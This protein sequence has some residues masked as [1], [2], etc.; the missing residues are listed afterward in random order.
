MVDILLAVYNG[1]KY[2]REQIKSVMEQSYTDWRLIICDDG[3]QDNS[4]AIIKEYEKACPKKILCYKNETPTGSA[5]GNFMHMLEYAS[6]EYIMFCDQDDFWLPEKISSTL[7]KM[8]SLE[9][10]DTPVLIHGELSVADEKLNILHERMSAY[11]RLNPSVCSLNRILAQNNV[12]GCT[13]MINRPLLELIKAIP[14]EKMLMHDWWAGI[15]AAAFGKIGFI[16]NPL[17][18]YRQHGDNQVGAVRNESIEGIAKI[19]FQFRKTKR[20]ITDTYMQAQAFYD[21]YKDILPE[22][23]KEC[24]KKYISVKDKNKL[25]RIIILIKY[26]YLKQSFLSVIGQLL[27]C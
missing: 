10:K 20:R 9:E 15:T 21:C 14:A 3:S 12:T 22:D 27:F 1:E 13:V 2:L 19:L 16:P 8:Q 5:K 23:K 18:L 17:I 6:A 24:I 11:Q 25:M 4:Y 7:K 26:R